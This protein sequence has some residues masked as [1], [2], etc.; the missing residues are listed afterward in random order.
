MGV[1][2]GKSDSADARW[3]AFD[4]DDVKARDYKIDTFKWIRDDES[5]DPN[6][7]ADPTELLVGALSELQLAIAEIQKLQG[8]IEPEA[9]E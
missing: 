6:D 1:Q 3:R 5:D 7:L 4:I 9:A 8:L 2:R